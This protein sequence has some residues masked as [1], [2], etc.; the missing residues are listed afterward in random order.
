MNPKDR[1]VLIICGGVLLWS[2][3]AIALRW[4]SWVLLL[5]IASILVW[6]ILYAM[7]HDVEENCPHCGAWL[8]DPEWWPDVNGLPLAMGGLDF[9]IPCPGCGVLVGNPRL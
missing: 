6:R 1:V 3:L 9:P 4:P 8:G 2:T 7:L 5:L